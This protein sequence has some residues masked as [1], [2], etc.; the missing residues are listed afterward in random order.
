[1]HK[2]KDIAKKKRFGLL[3]VIEIEIK[4]GLFDQLK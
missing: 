2:E 1:M 4:S 3:C